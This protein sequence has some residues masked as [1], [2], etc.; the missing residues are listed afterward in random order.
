MSLRVE[1]VTYFTL[2]PSAIIFVSFAGAG[3]GAACEVG[4]ECLLTQF[5][6]ESRGKIAFRNDTC[7]APTLKPVI[8]G[9]TKTLHFV[10]SKG[11]LAKKKMLRKKLAENFIIKVAGKNVK[12]IK[13]TFLPVPVVE[14]WEKM[15][16]SASTFRHRNNK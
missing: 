13:N 8:R 11:E 4:T 6:K 14:K 10:E 15:L 1:L 9:E 12:Q 5:W 3:G 2:S 16:P 7:K